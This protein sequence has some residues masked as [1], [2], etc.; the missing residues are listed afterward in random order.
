MQGNKRNVLVLDSGCSGHMTG[1]KSMMSEFEEKAGPAV[2]YG[3]GN[4]GQTLGY[5]NIEIG[6]VIIEKVALASGLKHMK[7]HYEIINKKIG[8]IVLTGYKHGNIYESNLSSNTDGTITCLMRKASV[9]DSWIW[10]N[11]LYHLNFNN[12]NE[13]VRKDLVRGLPKVIYTHDGLYDACQK[14]KQRRTSFKNKT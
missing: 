14:A 7:N 2:S 12:L 8:K 9:S 1:N 6:N 4:L 5:G 13:L 10:H 3:D 11:K